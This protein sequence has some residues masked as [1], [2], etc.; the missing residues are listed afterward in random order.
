[1]MVTARLFTAGTQTPE[2]NNESSVVVDEDNC[3][4]ICSVEFSSKADGLYYPLLR[5]HVSCPALMRRMA[6]QPAVSISPAPRYP[7]LDLV[8]DFT[9]HDQC[10]LAACINY[11]DQSNLTAVNKTLHFSASRFMELTKA[12]LGGKIISSYGDPRRRLKLTF[13]HYRRYIQNAHVAVVGTEIPWAEAML[14]NAGADRVT[15]LEYRELVIEHRRVVVT[16]PSQFA[17]NFLDATNIGRTVCFV[18]CCML[19]A[20]V[21]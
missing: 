17:K 13:A 4:Q 21:R 3:G 2:A 9:Q 8:V 14:I 12:D 20:A 6:R 16:T 15:T 11:Y 18:L 5:K 19:L 10:P 7:P 1:M